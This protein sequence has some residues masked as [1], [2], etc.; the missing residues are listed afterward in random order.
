[1]APRRRECPRRT[2]SCSK[3][4]RTAR[5]LLTK[6]WGEIWAITL[7]SQS[8]KQ[9][10]MLHMLRERSVRWSWR[11]RIQG[12]HPKV[13]QMN[14]PEGWTSGRGSSSRRLR[15]KNTSSTSSCSILPCTCHSIQCKHRSQLWHLR[16][17][18]WAC[19]SQCNKW[20]RIWSAISR[21]KLLRCRSR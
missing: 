17:C 3:T 11:R 1:M 2:S 8:W 7:F 20:T 15:V 4:R 14:T 13:S 5:P 6:R 16:W 9:V 19:S 18:Q 21:R 10:V 12:L